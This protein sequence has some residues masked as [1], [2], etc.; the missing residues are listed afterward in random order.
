MMYGYGNAMDGWGYALMTISFILLAGL[1]VYGIVAL[2]RHAGRGAP[3]AGG[4]PE[5]PRPQGPEGL[6]AGRYARGEINED[7][8][9]R[10]LAVLRSAVPAAR[11]EN[12]P[13]TP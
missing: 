4:P 8:Y 12:H 3:E 2:S 13:A 6:L 10:R 11:T 1:A 5:P 7:E 9:Q